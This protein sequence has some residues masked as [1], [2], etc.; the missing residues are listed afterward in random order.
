MSCPPNDCAKFWAH[1]WN[2][3]GTCSQSFLNQQAYFQTTLNWRMKIDILS[4]L[5]REG[6]E[7]NDS[8]YSVKS[9]RNAITKAIGVTPRIRIT[10]SKK[11]QKCQLSEVYFC[12]STA[13]QL[14]SCKYEVSTDH[15]CDNVMDIYFYKFI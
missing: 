10:Y 2:K 15:Y 8:V 12:V 9:I 1:E 7:P 14:T 5:K 6:I 11:W 13:N 3:H 4:A